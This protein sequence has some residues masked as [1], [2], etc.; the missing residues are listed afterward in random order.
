MDATRV[1]T[2]RADIMIAGVG[3]QGVILAASI[4]AETALLHGGLEVKESETHGMSQRGGSV[5]AQIRIG[6]RVIAPT[7]SPG[8][9]DFL[10][11]FEIAEGLRWAPS[12]ADEGVAIVNTERMVPPIVATGTYSYPDDALERMD[13]QGYRLITLDA[14]ALGEEAGSV[15]VAGVVLL[16]ALSNHLAFAQET[17]RRAI[18]S[19][20]NPSWL[21]VNLAAFAAGQRAGAGGGR[22]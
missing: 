12:V 14:N 11:A 15:K 6:D 19:T 8:E 1:G 3:G 17:W 9:V 4:V 2:T 20:V 16:G 18:A 5:Q 13:G 22:R 7:I 21:Q 10:L